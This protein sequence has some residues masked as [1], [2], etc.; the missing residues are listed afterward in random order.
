MALPAPTDSLRKTTP[1]V[2]VADDQPEMRSLIANMLRREGYTVTEAIDGAGLLDL[3]IDT[4]NN[5]IDPQIPDLIVTDIW[6]PGCSGLEILARLR[7]FAW[8]TRVIVITA[9]ADETAHT[10]ARRLGAALVL[11]KPFDLATLRKAAH[12]LAPFS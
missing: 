7:R 11:D 6:M 10:E 4:L 8:S 2:V 12:T 5:K 3:L 9:F 1:R